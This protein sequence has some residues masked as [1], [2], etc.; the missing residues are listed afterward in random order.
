MCVRRL[1]TKVDYDD[2]T[3]L[4][5]IPPFD[6]KQSGAV[7]VDRAALTGDKIGSV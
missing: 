6:K 2:L 7:S 1:S 3:T 4:A 5:S